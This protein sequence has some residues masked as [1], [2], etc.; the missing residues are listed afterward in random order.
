MKLR[1]FGRLREAAGVPER[2]LAPPADV[3]TTGALRHWLGKDMPALLSPSVKI[4]LDDR[5]VDDATS[6][7]EASE[8]SF[9]PPV[10]GG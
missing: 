2:E 9:L 3:T 4:A 10:S 5:M 8:V 6:L 7:A 1:F